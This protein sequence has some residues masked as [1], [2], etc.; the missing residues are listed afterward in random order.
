MAFA[1]E[2]IDRDTK[3]QLEALDAGD[4]RAVV[5]GKRIYMHLPRGFGGVNLLGVGS[6]KMKPP[7]TIRGWPTVL[8]LRDMA[9]SDLMKFRTTIKQGDK[10]ATG[11]QI[12]DD[13]IEQLGAGKK[14]PVKLTVNGY[15]YRSTVA[16]VDG[17]FMVGFSA[18]HRAKSG[19][20]GGDDVDVDIE[21]DTEPRT[22]E[23]PADF[24]ARPRRR[25]PGE[26][27]VRQAVQQPE[28]LSRLTGH[29][30]EVG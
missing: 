2:P 16:T 24:A 14:P 17:K 28:G 19:L 5:V 18:D 4:E 6:S 22:V 1:A 9:A 15:S 30:R 11:I 8:K 3:Q 21:L 25:A 27:H 12:P 20:K 26:S 7:V 23:V 29:R 13:V 10:T